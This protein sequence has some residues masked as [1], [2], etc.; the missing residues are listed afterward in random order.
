MTLATGEFIRRVLIHVLPKGFH[1]IR[2]YGLLAGSTKAE[3]LTKARKLLGVAMQPAN[4]DG[5]EA[6]TTRKRTSGP[7]PA[8]AARCA[9]SRRSMP[10]A[11]HATGRQ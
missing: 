11:S 4:D 6:E 1:R 10:A 7:V 9:S 8:A 3:M 2:H 5:V